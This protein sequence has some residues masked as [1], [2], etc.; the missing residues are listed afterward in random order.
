MNLLNNGRGRVALIYNP[1]VVQI[2]SESAGNHAQ[3]SQATAFD[4]QFIVSKILRQALNHLFPRNVRL[5]DFS[6]A[7]QT[8][9]EFNLYLNR[10][11]RTNFSFIISFSQL[12]R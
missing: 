8:F 4:L 6:I 10:I 3:P 1:G 11:L 7:M 5:R 2:S 9:D 12:V